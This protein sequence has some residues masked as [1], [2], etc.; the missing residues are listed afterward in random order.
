MRYYQKTY[1]SGRHTVNNCKREESRMHRSGLSAKCFL[2]FLVC[3]LNNYTTST[4][5][6][7]SFSSKRKCTLK[8]TTKEFPLPK[9]HINKK[10][11]HLFKNTNK[12]LDSVVNCK[13][14]GRMLRQTL[15]RENKVL[16]IWVLPKLLLTPLSWH[17]ISESL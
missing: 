5:V 4:D 7:Y 12:N 13:M 8:T 9:A 16:Y 1:P 11:P 15:C 3:F 14:F 10:S 6:V 17:N 2:V